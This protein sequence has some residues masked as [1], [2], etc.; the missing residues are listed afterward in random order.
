[1]QTSGHV[2]SWSMYLNFLEV[3]DQVE[4]KKQWWITSLFFNFFQPKTCQT[5]LKSLA[6]LI[7]DQNLDSRDPPL[8]VTSI[9]NYPK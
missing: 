1:M 8:K 2:F 7:K 6:W 3:E 4:T 9:K 5:V